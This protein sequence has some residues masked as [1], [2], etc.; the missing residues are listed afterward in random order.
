[1]KI[2]SNSIGGQDYKDYVSKL[3]KMRTVTHNSVLAN[4]NV[5]NRLAAKNSLPPVYDGI[6]SEE[7]PYRREVANAVLAYVE[8]IIKNRR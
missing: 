8:K 1:M 3:D 7:R 2:Y 5:L 4:V 6:V